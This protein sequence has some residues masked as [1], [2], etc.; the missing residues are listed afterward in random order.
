MQ[1]QILLGRY[2]ILHEIGKGGMGRVFLARQLDLP[3]QVVIK[4]MREEVAQ[5]RAFRQR[6]EQEMYLL[7]RFQHP[8]AVTLYDAT[9]DTPEGPC[10]VMEYVRG[11]PLDEVLKR[12]RHF[13]PARVGR[14][15]A[16]LC[17][18][19]Q[20][21][22]NLGILHRDLKPS[23]IM[24]LEPDTPYEKVKILDFG[25]AEL[26]RWVGSPVVHGVETG[27]VGTP[28]YMSPEQIRNEPL[29]HRSDL[30]SLGVIAYELLTGRLPF[31]AETAMDILLAHTQE[32]PRPMSQSVPFVPP[33]IEE[34]VLSCLAK[35]PEDRPSSA[36]EV[37]QRYQEALRQ[38]QEAA[39]PK[40]AS[41]TPSAHDTVHPHSTS[42]L[43]PPR[44]PFSKHYVLEA[45]IPQALAAYKIQGFVADVRGE[46]S[47]Q[48]DQR[49]VLR[50][51][52]K[53]TPY[54]V[55]QQGGLLQRWLG[56]HSRP[57]EVELLF[58]T[59]NA[60]GSR[61]RISVA[62]TYVGRLPLPRWPEYCDKILQDLRGYLM[63]QTVFISSP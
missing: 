42:R 13:S 58:E 11:Q 38:T 31:E 24:L 7:A 28:N 35:R 46:I 14:L 57:F 25:L 39:W 18:V 52:G 54:D 3:R 40:S 49:L 15:L 37:N 45:W 1:Q 17:E 56:R 59:L 5:D 53:N 27:L 48:E 9:L 10:L 47:L 8:Y 51:G 62:V 55:G 26:F 61:L 2:E 44:S 33:P 36:W 32:Q 23:N 22:H 29:D 6:F 21:A 19:L 20:A 43:F 34:V 16:Q 41:P 63:G 50:L 60:H 12:E 4:L 30:Y